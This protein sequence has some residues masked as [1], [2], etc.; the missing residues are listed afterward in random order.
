MRTSFLVSILVSSCLTVYAQNKGNINFYLTP[1]I[2]TTILNV[3]G[4]YIEEFLEKE[5]G[6]NISL[7]IPENY[8][9]LV[10]N[11]GAPEPCFAIMNSQSYVIANKKYGALVK[12]RTVRFGHSVYYGMLIT[13]VT[14]GIKQIKQLN[15]KSIAYTDQLSTSGY[16]YPKKIL[17]TY[18]I[19]PSKVT[20][21]KKHDE[22]VR[23]VYEGKVDAGA[24][25]YSPP[26]GSGAIR[27]ARMRI[28][29]K[30]PDVEKKVSILAITD[31]I[32][33]DPIVFSKNFNSDVAR[34]LYTALVKFAIDEKGKQILS[35]MYGT[36][37]FAKA[38]DADYNSLRSVLNTV[39]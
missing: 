6:L 28:Q 20:F 1:S 5:T 37:G 39:K 8:D 24:A 12:L 10:E 4:K 35:D 31:P 22:V 7:S 30:Y 27:D 17:D 9:A 3:N 15:G 21:V 16:L 33:N 36:E 13:N 11:F 26:S 29:D 32:P 19:K 23:L 34:K 14:S 25:F 38:N 2:S 18:G